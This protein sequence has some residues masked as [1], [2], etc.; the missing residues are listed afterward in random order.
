M[1]DWP[2]RINTR[3]P[4]AGV[5]SCMPV[6]LALG[7]CDESSTRTLE[8]LVPD[9]AE[10]L[11]RTDNVTIRIEPEGPSVTRSA[12]GLEFDA[13][14]DVTEHDSAGRLE[15][16]LAE[17]DR[18]IA[19]GRS[20][21]FVARVQDPPPA[22]LLGRPGRLSSYATLESGLV[23][24]SWS[25]AAG[26]RGIMTLAPDGATSFVSS[27]DFYREA[28]A[29]GPVTTPGDGAFVRGP[30]ESMVR[31]T[32]NAGLEAWSYEPGRDSWTPHPVVAPPEWGMRAGAA[33]LGTDDGELLY[34]FGG[35]THLDVLTL[36]LR[37]DA[38]GQLH[39]AIAPDWQ[40]DNPRVGASALWLGLPDSSTSTAVVFGGESPEGTPMAAF[41]VSQLI[42]P[43]ALDLPMIADW[44]SAGCTRWGSQ[45]PRRESLICLGGRDG[46]GLA[47][48]DAVVL[49]AEP[50]PSLAGTLSLRAEVLMGYLPAAI[51]E[52]RLFSDASAVYAEGDGSWLRIDSSEP[53]TVTHAPIAVLRSSGGQ[54]VELSTGATV[55]LGGEGPDGRAVTS[56]RAFVPTP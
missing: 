51:A 16:Y 6:C 22:L 20:A 49:A 10:D 53:H 25:A 7:A 34:V 18:L 9:T 13:A 52:P 19:W 44:T 56:W 8:F 38:Q 54:V 26:T 36:A 50:G 40:L 33:H 24:H 5:L 29:P 28:A 27:Y 31:L 47:R 17:G 37:P 55:L 2:N 12:E 4:S 1:I 46:A 39:A 30:G 21:N 43:P 3:N 11:Q 23:G 41:Q 35:G 48:S 45:S 15:L 42:G 32:W 14:L